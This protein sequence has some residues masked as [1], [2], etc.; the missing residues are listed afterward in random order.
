MN[1]PLFN[2]ERAAFRVGYVGYDGNGFAWRI[3][4]AGREW[5]A[6]PP[7]DFRATKHG[8]FQR[9]TLREI[10]QHLPRSA[11]VKP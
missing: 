8:A 10:S 3:E 9:R 4:R 5:I 7:Q 1:Q 2:I 6:R 11:G